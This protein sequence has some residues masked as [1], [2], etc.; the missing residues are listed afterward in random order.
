MSLLFTLTCFGVVNGLLIGAYRLLKPKRKV[1]DL[2]LG[3]LLLVLSIRIGKSVL[4]VFTENVDLL[5]L[6]IGLSA[7]LFIG[8]FYYLFVKSVRLKQKRT[9]RKDRIF[10]L[11]LLVAIVSI[12]F[13]FPY[14]QFPAIWNDYIVF[15]IYAV[16]SVCMLLGIAQYIK[17]LRQSGFSIKGMSREQHYL[18]VITIAILSITI[19]YQIALFGVFTYIWGAIIFSLVLYYII[20]SILLSSG[21]FTVQMKNRELKDEDQLLERLLHHMQTTRPYMRSDL[22][23]E[24][25]AMALSINRQ[26]LSQLLNKHYTHGFTQFLRE[27]R[28]NEAKKLIELRPEL[29]MEGVGSESGFRSN[30]AFYEAFKKIEN[31]TPAEY[32]REFKKASLA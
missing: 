28:I 20:G 1:P 31:C 8:P 11:S 6:Q 12:G 14:R 32:R 15:G 13:I 27:Y 26:T 21:N 9:E 10:L 30:S 17:M 24:D 22:K 29:S 19:T 25:L 23:L 16:W 18:T 3:G 4:Y 2:Y 7:C 5:I